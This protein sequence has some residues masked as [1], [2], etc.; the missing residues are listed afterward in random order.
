MNFK[1]NEVPEK[2]EQPRRKQRGIGVIAS[3]AKQSTCAL[4]SRIYVVAMDCRSRYAPSQ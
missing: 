3:A 1:D 2:N 4:E